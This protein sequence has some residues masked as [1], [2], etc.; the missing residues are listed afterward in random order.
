MFGR[1]LVDSVS[2]CKI[3][4]YELTVKGVTEGGAVEMLTLIA[5]NR[6]QREERTIDEKLQEVKYLESFARVEK[7]LRHEQTRTACFAVALE[8][9]IQAQNFRRHLGKKIQRIIGYEES[10]KEIE[11]IACELAS[12]PSSRPV[13]YALTYPEFWNC[14]KDTSKLLAVLTWNPIRPST[15]SF[16]T[17]MLTTTIDCCACVVISVPTATTL[18]KQ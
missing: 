8:K 17:S 4:L 18:P 5:S 7:N 10:G 13:T 9:A 12:A 16:S 11:Q 6:G 1:F 2:S 14:P 3:V 15:V